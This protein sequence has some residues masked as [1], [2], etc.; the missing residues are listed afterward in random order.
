MCVGMYGKDV[1][2]FVLKGIIEI[3]FVNVGFKGYEI[4]F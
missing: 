2:F 4:E 1:D 3:I